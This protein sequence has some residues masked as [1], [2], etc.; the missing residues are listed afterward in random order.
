MLNTITMLR[1]INSISDT[2][3]EY[4]KDDPV[5]PDIPRDFRV[6]C[7]RFVAALVEENKPTSMVC[8]SLHDFVPEC[9]ADLARTVEQPTVCVFYTIWSYKPGDG[10]KLLRQCVSEIHSKYSTVTTFVTLSPKTELAR[11]FHTK[12]G[13]V[14]FRENTDT[15]NYWYK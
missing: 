1:L 11:R 9:V 13:A 10:V 4:I 3:L 8:V 15:I 6:T 2:L 12:N 14:I 7:N 5:R